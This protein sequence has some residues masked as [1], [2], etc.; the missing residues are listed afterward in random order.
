MNPVLVSQEN[1][2]C[3]GTALQSPNGLF[4]RGNRTLLLAD[5]HI[6]PPAGS[7]PIPGNKSSFVHL[8]WSSVFLVLCSSSQG[9]Y[10]IPS[11][12]C[13]GAERADIIS[14]GDW[15]AGSTHWSQDAVL[16]SDCSSLELVHFSPSKVAPEEE[17]VGG[18]HLL[19]GEWGKHVHLSPCLSL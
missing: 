5:W 18:W 14:E 2:V 13:E 12:R 6:S 3:S 4:C 11:A 1:L 19:P 9:A 7:Q 16:S 10:L 15:L 8:P 17:G